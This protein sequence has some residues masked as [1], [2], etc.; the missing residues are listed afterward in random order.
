MRVLMSRHSEGW[1]HTC[2]PHAEVAIKKLGQGMYPL[3]A[4]P[5]DLILPQIPLELVG[6]V[7]QASLEDHLDLVTQAFENVRIAIGDQKE[8]PELRQCLH[9]RC[10]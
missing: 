8:L 10:K 7:P 1:E 9:Q 5:L 3:L 6:N 2:L 4:L